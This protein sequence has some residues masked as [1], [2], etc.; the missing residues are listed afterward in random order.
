MSLPK[1]AAGQSAEDAASGKLDEEDQ[2]KERQPGDDLE[3]HDPDYYQYKL[4]GVLVHMGSANGGHYYSYIKQRSTDLQDADDTSA[5]RWFEFNDH[6]VREIDPADLPAEC[7]GGEEQYHATG[8]HGS[9]TYTQ[10]K[11]RNAYMLIYSRCTPGET[12]KNIGEEELP[13]HGFPENASV[14]SYGYGGYGSGGYGSGGYSTMRRGGRR[15]AYT[16]SS[17]DSD[18]DDDLNGPSNSPPAAAMPRVDVPKDIF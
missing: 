11:R 17:W 16:W 5:G 13:N 4:V 14:R 9:Q 6:L 7:F 10:P 15:S 12:R 8:Y 18:S 2:D 3:E 1:D